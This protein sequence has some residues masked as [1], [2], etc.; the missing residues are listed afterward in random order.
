VTEETVEITTPAGSCDAVIYRDEAGRRRPGVLYLTDIFG[1]RDVTRSCA[2][3]V[4]SLGYTVLLPNLFYRTARPPVFD[5]KPSFPDERTMKRFAELT[6]P[7]TPA[8]IESDAA[9]YVDALAAH[10]AV[11]AEPVRAV[12]YCFS[13]KMAMY[14]AAARPAQVAV[15]ASFHGGGL[16]TEDAASPHLL[17]PRINPATTRLYFGHAVQDRSM[18][19]ETI[20]KLGVALKAWGGTYE[21]ETYEGASHGWTV[22]GNPAYNEPQAERA[23]RK[24]SELFAKHL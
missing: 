3:R 18:P 14:A 9:A 12:G 6:G 2:E 21:N 13:G 4:A 10:P 5:F 8:A 11:S 19:A 15:V 24:L 16:V 7:L 22:P 23:F 1:I 20:E 17:L